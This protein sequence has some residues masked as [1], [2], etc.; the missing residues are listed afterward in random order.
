M[1]ENNELKAYIDE[2]MTDEIDNDRDPYIWLKDHLNLA[3]KSEARRIY[4]Q[5]YRGSRVVAEEVLSGLEKEIEEERDPYKWLED[6][7]HLLS[8]EDINLIRSLFEE[9]HEDA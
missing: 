5:R 6:N 2:R 3:S 9:N 7:L 1:I 8:K 4:A